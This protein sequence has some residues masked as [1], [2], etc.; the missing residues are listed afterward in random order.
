M[1]AG[2]PPGCAGHTL[3]T[4]RV[5]LQHFSSARLCR[6][7]CPDAALPPAV[8]QFHRSVESAVDSGRSRRL[9]TA[10]TAPDIN[11][12]PE[13][14]VERP[15]GST[16]CSRTIQAVSD[17]ERRA[18]STTSAGDIEI[19]HQRCAGLSTGPMHGLRLANCSLGVTQNIE[20]QRPLSKRAEKG[21]GSSSSLEIRSTFS[22][23]RA[24]GA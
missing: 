12:R 23:A 20:V 16:S 3:A 21:G 17:A 5:R 9:S 18:S 10:S 15:D 22:A 24:R 2:P 14:V 4:P 7:N 13:A 8:S 11:R 6:R 1:R 19:L